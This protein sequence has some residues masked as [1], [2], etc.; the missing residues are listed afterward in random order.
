MPN[1]VLAVTGI[2]AGASLLG[3]SSANRAASSAQ[4]SQERAAARGIAE[5]RR[6]FEASRAMLAPFVQGG[7]DAFAQQGILAGLGTPEEQQAAIA[8]IEAGPQFG[9]MVQQGENAILQNAAATGGL[10]GGNTQGALAQFRPAVLSQLIDQQY[11]RLGGLATIGQNSAAMTGAQGMQLGQNVS[12]LYGQQGAAQAG[13]ALAG[14]AN[15]QAALSGIAGAAGNLFAGAPP[16]PE[17]GTIFSN[18]GGF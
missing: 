3:Q 6:Q 18:W 11:S 4:A 14:G 9:A 16:M 15:A 8:A 13:R 10:R 7:T 17:G 12:G 1:P 5:Q 2:S